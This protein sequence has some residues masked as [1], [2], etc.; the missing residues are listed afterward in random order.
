M[1]YLKSMKN[2]KNNQF[3][4]L[5]ISAA[6]GKNWQ[7]LRSSAAG[8]LVKYANKSC[9]QKKIL[10]VEYIS[11]HA[12]IDFLLEFGKWFESAGVGMA[13]VLSFFA[14]QLLA[15]KNIFERAH[16]QQI[17]CRENPA[18]SAAVSIA[19]PPLPAGLQEPDILGLIY[20]VMLTEGAKNRSGA[21]YT[22]RNI[23][24]NMLNSA[25]CTA[26]DI[27][28]PCC[29]SGSILLTAAEMFNL[30]PEKLCGVDNDP[31]AVFIA[32]VNLLLAFPGLVFTPRIYCADYCRNSGQ[33]E[34]LQKKFD[35]IVTNPP[36]GAAGENDF[37]ESFAGVFHRAAQQLAPG[38]KMV[39]L[40]PE[41]VL[42]VK[43]HSALRRY[44]LNELDLRSIRLYKKLFS[45]VA[46]GFVEIFCRNG[47]PGKNIILSLPDGTV[48]QV[49]RARYIENANCNFS[50]HSN[51]TETL[52]KHIEKQKKHTLKASRWAL[53]IVTGNN[54]KL[55][56]TR[57]TSGTEAVFC[58]R[59]ITPYCIA[60]ASRYIGFDRSKFQQCAPD[61]LYRAPEKLVYRFIAEKP[62]FALDDQQHLFLN[63][64]NIL[65]PQ[66]PGMSIKTVMALLNSKVL[67]FY[68]RYRC[69]GRKVLKSHLEMLPFPEVDEAADRR[70]TALC[71][72]LAAGEN[73]CA[74]EIDRI[75]WALYNISPAE[76]KFIESSFLPC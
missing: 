66:I 26:G 21:Y 2:I 4:R 71:S 76:Q 44:I 11:S 24:R 36:W 53:G 75:I 9:S 59:D 3:V 37:S 35:L 17:F 55:I 28:D 41:A 40:L 5:D 49:P 7:R 73:E 47:S 31:L 23:V 70:L 29:G 14:A 42:N 1:C 69:G 12:A 39:F 20:Q 72:R 30:P 51:E 65:I 60:P 67:A 19:P 57:K 50:L 18:G 27:F 33:F 25:G 52:L 63:S 64:A 68:Y 15:E 8:R 6:T 61:E 43:K 34:L 46:T 16:V 38:G 32:R 54:S 62:V 10:P 74:G 22:P 48:H 13:E 56:S 58:G 45:G